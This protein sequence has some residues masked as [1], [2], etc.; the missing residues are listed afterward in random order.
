MEIESIQDDG[1]KFIIYGS[2]S[3]LE[4]LRQIFSDVGLGISVTDTGE[5]AFNVLYTENNRDVVLKML[6]DHLQ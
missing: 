6:H 2:Y 1:E 3:L 4:E 5:G